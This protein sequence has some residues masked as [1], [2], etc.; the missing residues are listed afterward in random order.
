MPTTPV[1]VNYTDATSTVKSRKGNS[2]TYALGNASTSI[3]FDVV[4]NLSDLGINLVL[5]P[6]HLA[7]LDVQEAEGIDRIESVEELRFGKCLY[8]VILRFLERDTGLRKK[9]YLLSAAETVRRG[10]VTHNLCRNPLNRHNPEDVP[11]DVQGTLLVTHQ[12][13]RLLGNESLRVLI[14]ELGDDVDLLW[15]L[16]QRLEHL[17]LFPLPPFGCIGGKEKPWTMDDL[18]DPVQEWMPEFLLVP[19]NSGHFPILV[20]H[21]STVGGPRSL[22]VVLVLLVQVRQNF[23]HGWGG[24]EREPS[25]DTVVS[26]LLRESTKEESTEHGT[27]P[28]VLWRPHA[29]GVTPGSEIVWCEVGS[30]ETVSADKSNGICK[31]GTRDGVTRAETGTLDNW[32]GGFGLEASVKFKMVDCPIELLG[33]GSNLFVGIPFQ[34]RLVWPQAEVLQRRENLG[35]ET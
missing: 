24:H 32:F 23:I 18:G 34:E 4:E 2:E 19:E 13:V 16:R 27:K 21:T 35:T 5:S 31:D 7:S 33:S 11:D 10:G 26:K 3:S 20:E 15:G 1:T 9:R 14:E 30:K 29:I 25:I 12:F 6:Q 28:G 17:P 22:E 8:S